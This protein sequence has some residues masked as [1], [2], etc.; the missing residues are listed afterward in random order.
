MTSA[1]RRMNSCADQSPSLVAEPL[2]RN[3]SW[4]VHIIAYALLSPLLEAVATRSQRGAAKKKSHK[5]THP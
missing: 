5:K 2:L 1:A 4:K 3:R